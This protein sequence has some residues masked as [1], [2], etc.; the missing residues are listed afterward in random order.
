[1]PVIGPVWVGRLAEPTPELGP[2]YGFGFEYEGF[3]ATGFAAV[4]FAAGLA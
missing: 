2:V 3:D 1:M 4:F